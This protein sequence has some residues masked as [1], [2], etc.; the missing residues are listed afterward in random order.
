MNRYSAHKRFEL[1]KCADLSMICICLHIKMHK[2]K[3]N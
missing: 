1:L 3:W 2:K